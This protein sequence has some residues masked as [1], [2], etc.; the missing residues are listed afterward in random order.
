M[1]TVLA[2]AASYLLAKA[3]FSRIASSVRVWYI[4]T[5][6]WCAFLES[7][8]Y[9]CFILNSDGIILPKSRSS[10]LHSTAIR[11][12]PLLKFLTLPATI[13]SISASSIWLRVGFIT[14]LSFT[15]ATLHFTDD[16]F[17][18]H[19]RN[20]YS[21]QRAARHAKASGNTSDHCWLM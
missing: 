12:P 11:L 21:C 20:C 6:A 10:S 18:G 13:K 2:F 17:D 8:L 3:Y 4:K 1:F 16:F 5:F 19:I 15:L 7:V 14:N 9:L